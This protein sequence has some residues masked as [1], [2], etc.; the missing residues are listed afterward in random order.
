MS[1]TPLLI[2]PERFDAVLFDLDGVLTDTAKLHATCWKRMF[3]EFLRARSTSP[4]ESLHPFDMPQDY[5]RYIDGKLRDDGVQSFLASRG[6]IL[7]NG[8]LNDPPTCETVRGLGNRKNELFQELLAS[9]GVEAY[10]NSVH[11]VRWLR[12][13]GLRTAVVSASRNCPVVLAAAGIADLFD[14]RVDG[15]IAAQLRLAGKPAPDTF[16]EAARQLAVDP[17]RA[18]V[19]EDAIAGVQAGKAG[20]FGLV[21]GVA[22]KNDARALTDN[23]ADIIV[24]DLGE[25][26]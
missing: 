3:D 21:I 5:E 8:E 15:N 22:R 26:C 4:G 7:P 14:T 12:N 13:T 17:K 11:F 2:T 9:E 25:L 18:V 19:V 16:L 1:R 6:V 20:D 10:E 24:S 23:G